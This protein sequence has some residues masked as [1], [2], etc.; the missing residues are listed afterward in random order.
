MVVVDY[1]F[2]VEEWVVFGVGLNLLLDVAKMIRGGCVY[3]SY[4]RLDRMT[5]LLTAMFGHDGP[6]F[7]LSIFKFLKLSSI[8]ALQRDFKKK[9]RGPFLRIPHHVFL[10][11]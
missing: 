9:P 7:S 6:G 11:P 4:R 10:A 3:Q 8:R 1:N 5:I 2:L